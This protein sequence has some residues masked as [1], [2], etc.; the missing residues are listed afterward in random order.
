ME[1]P[2]HG[3]DMPVVGRLVGGSVGKQWMS[4][5]MQDVPDRALILLMCREKL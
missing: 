4:C 1:A 2:Q 5:K 3:V